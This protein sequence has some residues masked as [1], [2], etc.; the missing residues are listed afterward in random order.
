MLTGLVPQAELYYRLYQWVPS[1]LLGCVAA[2]YFLRASVVH[3]LM[4]SVTASATMF[5]LQEASTSLLSPHISHKFDTVFNVQY[6]ASRTALLS[7][8]VCDLLWVL[9]IV[10][11]VDVMLRFWRKKNAQGV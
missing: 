6:W 1:T 10:L 3:K 5:L 4:L 11:A 8:F 9:C 7:V 2:L